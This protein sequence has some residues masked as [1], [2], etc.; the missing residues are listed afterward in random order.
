MN[1]LSKSYKKRIVKEIFFLMV[2]VTFGGKPILA[3]QTNFLDNF[4]SY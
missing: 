3:R 2:M 1:M 4:F